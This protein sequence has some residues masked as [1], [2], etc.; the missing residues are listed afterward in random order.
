LAKTKPK[1]LDDVPVDNRFFVC[2]GEIL[3][4]L[5]QLPD[6]L[7]RMDDNVYNYHVNAEKNDFANWIETTIKDKDLSFV[8]KKAKDKSDMA[9]KVLDKINRLKLRQ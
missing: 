3:S 2:N 8:V 1:I 6:A 7:K 9:R 5:H 4:N